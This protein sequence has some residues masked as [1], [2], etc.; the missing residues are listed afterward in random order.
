VFISTVVVTNRGVQERNSNEDKNSNPRSSSSTQIPDKQSSKQ[1]E[2]DEISSRE[3]A[4]KE[5]R[6]KQ[7]ADVV[8]KFNMETLDVSK[9]LQNYD[10]SEEDFLTSKYSTILE[11]VSV[12]LDVFQDIKIDQNSSSKDDDD[13]D[14]DEVKLSNVKITTGDVV[15]PFLPIHP[16]S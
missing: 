9:Q 11:T 14:G 16:K 6:H 15:V 5:L 1:R 4:I 13:D 3:K 8:N 2:I 7:Y 10:E 12:N